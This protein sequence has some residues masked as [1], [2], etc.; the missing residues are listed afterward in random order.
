MLIPIFLTILSASPALPVSL[1]V[2][3]GPGAPTA[4][5][6]RLSNTGDAPLHVVGHRGLLS[7]SVRV[8]GRRAPV[9]CT[10]PPGV[11]PA[12]VDPERVT[13]LAPGASLAEVVDVRWLCWSKRASEA[14]ATPGA[15]LEVRY[16][17]RRA[18]A[19]TWVASAV[20]G[21]TR[22]GSLDAEPIP[23]PVTA[24][25]AP[26]AAGPPAP[27][28]TLRGAPDRV[29][30]ASG[31]SVPVSLRLQNASP[32]DLRVF[33]RPEL[34][35]FDVHGPTESVRCGLPTALRAPLRESFT[36]LGPRRR[37]TL[38][39]DVAA[40]CPRA[41]FATPGV[42]DVQPVFEATEDGERRGL[43]AFTGTIAGA[44]LVVRVGQGDL[45]EY[46]PREPVR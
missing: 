35:R 20:D 38:T 14:L 43:R 9:R 24:P 27:P 11:R 40:V 26:P 21:A 10:P 25:A 42:Y 7:L 17:F 12:S 44:P 6:F 5:V 41:T 8:P 29:D 37:T 46:E 31:R 39:L 23:A 19:R 16:G 32:D 15:T 1:R 3:P 45:P 13:T 36:R 33:V 4:V 28:L 18:S 2:E 30:S 34:F 22:V